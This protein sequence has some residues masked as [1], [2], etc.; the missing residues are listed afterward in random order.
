MNYPTGRRD[1]NSTLLSCK[2]T[3]SC[4]PDCNKRPPVH[5]NSQYTVTLIIT[6]N[7]IITHRMDHGAA[8]EK[9]CRVCG[10]SVVS[11]SVKTKYPCHKLQEKLMEVFG[12]AVEFDNPTKHPTHFCHACKSILNKA[13]PNYRHLTA[14]FS[15]WCSHME[16]GGCAVCEQHTLILRGGRPKRNHG[17]GRPTQ[18][19]PRYCMDHIR[20]VAPAPLPL[21]HG[22]ICEAHLTVPLSAVE[23]PICCYILRSPVELV[24][25][26]NVVCAECLCSWLKQKNSLACPCCFID[27]LQ[28]FSTIRQ[29]APLV[30][31]LLCVVCGECKDHVKLTTYCDH[32]CQP[33]MGVLPHTN[34]DDLL[35]QSVTTP[36]TAIEQKLQTSLVRR[37]LSTSSENIL[38]LKTGGK[39]LI[40]H[41][42]HQSSL[43]PSCYYS[44]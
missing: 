9:L 13:T 33:A 2:G 41:S 30:V 28:D 8:L 44:H 34:I 14:G 12:I 23:C 3:M 31:T 32:N 35:N 37:S 10:R 21:H 42:W 25:C 43:Y 40:I 26:M 22:D 6:F 1:H 18:I 27:H 29:A 19:S 36:L 11:R 15:G 39:V 5:T 16:D 20:A 24:T 4:F 38:Q 17:A 7:I